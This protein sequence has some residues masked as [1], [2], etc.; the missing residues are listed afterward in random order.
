MLGLLGIDGLA[1]SRVLDLDHR[2][3]QAAKVKNEEG[4]TVSQGQDGLGVGGRLSMAEGPSE[5]KKDSRSHVVRKDSVGAYSSN[6]ETLPG[7][8]ESLVLD[9]L[10]PGHVRLE[11][12]LEVKPLLLLRPPSRVP[13]ERPPEL[14][15]LGIVRC[16][17]LVDVELFTPDRRPTLDGLGR[18]GPVVGRGRGRVG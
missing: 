15:E 1:S 6:G 4:V 3:K 18:G 12:L 10:R 5:G 14:E 7:D 9:V 11:P 17:G 8:V 2:V 16:E 13:G